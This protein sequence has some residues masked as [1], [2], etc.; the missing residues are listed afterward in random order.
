M[1]KLLGKIQNV[2]LEGVLK[3]SYYYKS[4]SKI[5]NDIHS[6]IPIEDYN[7]KEVA[8]PTDI[9]EE[10]FDGINYKRAVMYLMSNG[11]E[12]A[13]KGAHG[14]AM[15]GHL[16]KQARG[17]KEISVDDYLHQFEGEF[18]RIDF[19]K[20]P[21]LNLFNNGS[22]LNDNELPA[23]ASSEMLKK[24][25]ANPDIKMLVLETRPEFVTEEKVKEIKRL[26][27]DKYVEI[28]IG[29]EVKDDIYRTICVNKGFSSIILI[30]VHMFY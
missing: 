26:I 1:E 9:R 14:C 4:I 23:K 30:C 27:P 29:L 12:W 18:E 2:G 10:I 15:C 6:K 16:A 17:Y 8:F 19:K 11:C 5:M 24:I 20:Y 13:L 3:K 25:N 7:T 22:F 28:A 21:L